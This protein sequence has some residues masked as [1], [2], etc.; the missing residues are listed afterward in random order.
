[1][2]KCSRL[3][4]VCAPQYLF[5]GTSTSP[6]LSNSR[7]IPVASSP[8]GMSRIFGVWLSVTVMVWVLLRCLLFQFSVAPLYV[9]GIHS[10]DSAV[11][12]VKRHLLATFIRQERERKPIRVISPDPPVARSLKRTWAVPKCVE[13]TKTLFDPLEFGKGPHFVGKR[14]HAESFRP[15]MDRFGARQ[16]QEQGERRPF[17]ADENGHSVLPEHLANVQH[18]LVESGRA[19][20]I[21]DGEEDRMDRP[22]GNTIVHVITTFSTSVDFLYKRRPSQIWPQRQWRRIIKANSSR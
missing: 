15:E 4:W 19:V 1:M 5:A 17:V 6:R 8:M 20:E 11:K 10:S 18:G 7:R 9:G 21:A 3:R 2:L 22:N 12:I 16:S 13:V 14:S